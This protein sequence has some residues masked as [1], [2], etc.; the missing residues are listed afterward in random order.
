MPLYRVR[1]K[2]TTNLNGQSIDK[3]LSVDIP[4]FTNLSPIVVDE[5][6]LVQDAFKRVHGIDLKKLNLLNTNWLEAL[7]V[8]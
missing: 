8:G 4:M 3:G 5:G 2:Q 7:V 1:I 6:S